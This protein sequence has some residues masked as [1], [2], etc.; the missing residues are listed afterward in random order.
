[1]SDSAWSFNWDVKVYLSSFLILRLCSVAIVKALGIFCPRGLFHLGAIQSNFYAVAGLLFIRLISGA[2]KSK[3][4]WGAIWMKQ[5]NKKARSS[6]WLI[7]FL[8]HCSMG[9]FSVT[10][11]YAQCKMWA[12]TAV[13]ASSFLGKRRPNPGKGERARS[14]NV[15][16]AT[17]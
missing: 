3:S 13:A 1:M 15:F 4:A 10:R 6:S 9:I 5:G 17:F 2:S 7:F 11:M 8:L 16:R 14:L 12:L